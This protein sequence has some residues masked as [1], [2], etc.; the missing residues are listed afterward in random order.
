MRSWMASTRASTTRSLRP[1][2]GC[3]HQPAAMRPARSALRCAP[4]MVTGA[5]AGFQRSCSAPGPAED[6]G[7][8]LPELTWRQAGRVCV[9]DDRAWTG[10]AAD[11]GAERWRSAADS[12]RRGPGRYPRLHVW[13]ENCQAHDAIKNISSPRTEHPDTPLDGLGTEPLSCH[14]LPHSAERNS[15][16][17]NSRC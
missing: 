16:D 10:K 5:P 11:H 9:S 1:S 12:D 15:G 4:A 6:G 14:R 7:A 17:G 2:I 3:W 13:L 8:G